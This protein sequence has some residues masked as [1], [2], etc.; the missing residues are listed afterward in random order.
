MAVRHRG[1]VRS[2]LDGQGTFGLYLAGYVVLFRVQKDGTI[3][4]GEIRQRPA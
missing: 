1:F 2:M 3:R 4:V